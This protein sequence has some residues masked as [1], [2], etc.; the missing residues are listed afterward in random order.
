MTVE[1]NKALVRRFV[2]GAING[3]QIE[4]VDELA[5]GELAIAAKRWIGPFTESFPDFEMKI[6]QLIAEGDSVVAHFR[7]TGTHLGEW[8]GIPPSGDRFRDVDEIYIFR[9]DNGEL[10]AFTAVEDNLTR[11]RQLGFDLRPVQT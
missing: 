11:L 10:V 6:V 9:I 8:Q 5:D 4:L 2:D 1:A 7:C 3:R